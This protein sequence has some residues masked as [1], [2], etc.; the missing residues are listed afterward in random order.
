[1]VNLGSS[2]LI[3]GLLVPVFTRLKTEKNHKKELANATIQSNSVEDTK[4]VTKN[5]TIY[6]NHGNNPVTDDFKQISKIA[7]RSETFQSFKQRVESK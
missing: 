6:P 7:E 1:M 4:N 2:L 5:V 3:L